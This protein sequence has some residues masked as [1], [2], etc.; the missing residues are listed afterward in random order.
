VLKRKPRRET[1]MPL[2]VYSAENIDYHAYH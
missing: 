1:L 2:D